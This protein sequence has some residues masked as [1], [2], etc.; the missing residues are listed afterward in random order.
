MSFGSAM[1]LGIVALTRRSALGEDWRGVLGRALDRL[2]YANVVATLALFIALGG[3]A[4]AVTALPRNSV[5]TQQLKRN[6][7]TS[8]KIRN[9]TVAPADLSQATLRAL[10]GR[11]EIGRAH[12]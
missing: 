9:R 7:V 3:G 4:Y 2:T 11:A 10:A 8:A 12:V 6:A 5:G 1:R